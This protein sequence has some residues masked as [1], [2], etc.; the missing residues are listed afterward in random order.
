M[1]KLF[2]N[3]H[4]H[5]IARM[6]LGA[7]Y[8]YASFDK[9]ANAQAFAD[10]ISNYQMLPVQLVNPLAIF[11]PWVELITGLFLITGKWV[12]G[13]L[14]IYTT[15]L[16]I[17]I[18]ALAQAL[19]RGLDISCGCFSV[20]PSSTSD[21]WLRLIEDIILL[22]VSVNL[23]RFTPDPQIDNEHSINLNKSI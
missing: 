13:S 8:M 1:K 4:F 5:L 6:V 22:F 17:F 19:I 21:V 23:Y 15:L 9:L 11:L 7:I 12:K 14:L 20:K 2:G 10:V 3:K 16:V 18:I